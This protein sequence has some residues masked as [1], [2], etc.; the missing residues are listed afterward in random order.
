MR[1]IVCIVS[2]GLFV[3]LSLSACRSHHRLPSWCIG[4]TDVR[5]LRDLNYA[6]GKEQRLDLVLP[7]STVQPVPLIVWIHGGAW[8]G[9]DKWDCPGQFLVKSGYAV[10]SINYRLMQ[11]AVFP[12]QLQDCKAAIRWLRAHSKEFNLDAD[13]IGV[14]GPS[15]GG[16]LSALIGTTCGVRHLEGRLGSN[17]FSSCVQAVCDWSG[18]ANL[19]TIGSQACP[20]TLFDPN[21]KNV[22]QLRLIGG[23]RRNLKE[24]LFAASPIA[25]VSKD[26]P[27][28]LIMHGDADTVVPLGQSE[29]L[30]QALKSAGVDVEFIIVKH[31]DHSAFSPDTFQT[32]L[33]FFNAKL[34][35]MG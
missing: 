26:C 27:P 3:C 21:T 23:D 22:P 20:G 24:K 17:E 33:D 1:R 35:C 29:E 14:W 11:D 10:A 5:I 18:P 13:R 12:A 28:F 9:G 19:V 6:A 8:R 16:H 34:R 31:A 4:L 15:S 32:V 30:Y 25:Y 2:V 7:A